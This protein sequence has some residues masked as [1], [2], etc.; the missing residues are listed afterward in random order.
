MKRTGYSIS[1]ACIAVSLVCLCALAEKKRPQGRIGDLM[2]IART[3][4]VANVRNPSFFPSP[5][6]R[7]RQAVKPGYHDVYFRVLFR[8]VGR[9]ALCTRF[10]VT[11]ESTFSVDSRGFVTFDGDAS[12]NPFPSVTRLLPGEEIGAEVV[13]ADEKNGIEARK[14]VFS[15]T[16]ASQDCS[17]PHRNWLDSTPAKISVQN[18]PAQTQSSEHP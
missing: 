5:D 6:M 4:E 13:F 11:L 9:Q 15:P 1:V 8:N 10:K 14:L 12:P 17:S 16:G 2:V 7:S 18:I 3:I